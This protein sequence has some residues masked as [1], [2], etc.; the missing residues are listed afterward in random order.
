[1]K[2]WMAVQKRKKLDHLNEGKKKSTGLQ[3]SPVRIILRN[4]ADKNKIEAIHHVYKIILNTWSRWLEMLIVMCIKM[5]FAPGVE[6][7]MYLE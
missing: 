6:C 3:I 4:I 2:H 7:L 1:M 5:P